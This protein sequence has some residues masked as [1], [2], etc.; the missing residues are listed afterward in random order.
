MRYD[1]HNSL[2]PLHKDDLAKEQSSRRDRHGR[3]HQYPVNKAA[4]GMIMQ[5]KPAAVVVWRLSYAGAKFL[6]TV[7]Y[8]ISF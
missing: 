1:G 6:L 3:S 4:A 7:G 2:L 8:I 5:I